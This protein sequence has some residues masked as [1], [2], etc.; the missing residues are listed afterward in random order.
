MAGNNIYVQ[1]SYIDI[2]D[3]E[4]VYL[5]VDKAEVKVGDGQQVRNTEACPPQLTRKA[6]A[7]AL[8]AVQRYMWGASA[9][10]VLFCEC[11]D[12]WGYPNNMAQF[13]R[14]VESIGQEQHLDWSCKPGTL[15]DAFRNNPYLEKNVERW[16]DHGAKERSMMLLQKFQD[17][18]AK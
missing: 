10:A 15:S 11:R 4:N 9:Y 18:L 1:G 2:H 8:V 6:L 3:N 16:H 7:E 12:H 17:N 14:E 13:E 5:S